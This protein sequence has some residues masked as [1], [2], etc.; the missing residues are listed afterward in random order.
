MQIQ[1]DWP[2]ALH[3]YAVWREIFAGQN[4][5]QTTK[6]LTAKFYP[7]CKP[8]PFPAIGVAY[9]QSSYYSECLCDGIVPLI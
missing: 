5:P 4:F 9:F 1:V 3:M 6:I 2:H 7:Q 8:H